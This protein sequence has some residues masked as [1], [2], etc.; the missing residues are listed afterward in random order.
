MELILGNAGEA[1]TAHDLS[2]RTDGAEVTP[3]ATQAN[4]SL[5]FFIHGLDTPVFG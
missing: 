5:K 1:Q 4:R 3:T 2:V